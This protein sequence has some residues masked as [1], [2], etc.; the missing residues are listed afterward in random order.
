MRNALFISMTILAGPVFADQPAPNPSPTAQF[1]AP[2][3]AQKNPYAS[4]FTVQDALKQ[5]QQRLAPAA[6][7]RTVVCGMTIIEAD[8]YF[9]AKMRVTPPK[10]ADVRYTIRAV[11]PAICNPARK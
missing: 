5:A 4:L 7:N 9:D 2:R 11:D 10:D 6:P 8:P 3:R 1:G